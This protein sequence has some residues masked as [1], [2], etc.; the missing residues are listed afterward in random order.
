MSTAPFEQFINKFL[1]KH[2]ALDQLRQVALNNSGHDTNL[3]SVVDRILLENYMEQYCSRDGYDSDKSRTEISKKLTYLKNK[4]ISK[5]VHTNS[6]HFVIVEISIYFVD[7]GYAL[8]KEL[9]LYLNKINDR[10]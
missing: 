4:L 6:V 5:N 2:D 8:S 7:S 1:Q 10:L 3:V 9:L